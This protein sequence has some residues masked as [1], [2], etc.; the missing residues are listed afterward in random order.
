MTKKRIDI[1]CDL[2]EREDEA[3]IAED[4]ALMDY[5]SSCN[6]ACGFHAGN[7]SLMQHMVKA[8]QTADMAIGAHPSYPDREHF[9]RKDMQL[10]TATFMAAVCYQV[11][12]LNSICAQ[13]GATLRHVKAHGALYNRIA[14][15]IDL[16]MV[17]VQAVHEINHQL[18][19]YVP[20]ASKFEAWCLA[21]NIPH[22]AEGFADRR[23][24]AD[25]RLTPRSM[26]GAVI[27]RE[28][29]VNAQLHELLLNERVI[30]I[31]GKEVAMTAKTIC[32]H[33]DSPNA[34]ALART[35]SAF[36]KDHG[37]G[38]KAGI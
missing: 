7:E 2:G 33:S 24:L 28:E 22:L 12:K 35:I 27:E 11:D 37:F 13:E 1:N 36:L 30:S 10:D 4:I 38:L 25:G 6:I 15:D 21:N 20:A 23:Y 3:G 18:V 26:Q 14:W 19:L 5:I 16:A 29:D 17:F 9:G 8:A 32:L 34:L 31:D